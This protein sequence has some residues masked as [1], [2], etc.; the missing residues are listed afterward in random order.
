MLIIDIDVRPLAFGE[1]IHEKCLRAATVQDDGPL[2]L[3]LSLT[4]SGDPLFDDPAAKAGVDLAIFGTINSLTQ[5]RVRNPFRPGKAMK[6][7]GFEDSHL[8]P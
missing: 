2:A 4:R 6:P 7:P 3:R 1:P 8:W 5:S